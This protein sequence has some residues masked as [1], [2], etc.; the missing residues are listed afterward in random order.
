MMMWSQTQN[1]TLLAVSNAAAERQAC[2]YLR[3]AAG[4]RPTP[5]YHIYAAA[6]K[7]P[8]MFK[9]LEQPLHCTTTDL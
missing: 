2:W 3:A 5:T 8:N 9:L 6:K 1:T 7:K 4:V